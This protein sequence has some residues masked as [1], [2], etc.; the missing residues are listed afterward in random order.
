MILP[1]RGWRGVLLVALLLAAGDV[2][3]AQQPADN[4]VTNAVLPAPPIP[5][6]GVGST[7]FVGALSQLL[8]G[9]AAGAY[10]A[11]KN[12]PDA[13]ER[14]TIQ[15]AAIRF[16]KGIDAETIA[17]FAAEAPDFDFASV[18]RARLEAALDLTTASNETVIRLLGGQMP[19]GLDAQ[20]ALAKAYVADGQ[21]AR[22][23]R[24][25]RFIWVEEF[26][27]TDGE[28]KVQENLGTLLSQKDYWDRA[29][30]LLMHD[31]AS[32]TERIMS[33]LTPAEQSLARARIAVSR[34]SGDI[35]GLIE[36]VDSSLRDH[37][38]FQFTVA[39]WQRD[40][41]D[42][43]GAVAA[44][45]RVTSGEVPDA[46]EFW[47]ERR[48]IVR[49]ALAAGK[50]DL[51]YKAAAGYVAGPEG[52]LVEAHFHAGWVALVYLN[53]P[54][55]AAPH[56]KDM[57]RLATLPDS[58]SQ[59]R[60]WLG[61]AET[62]LGNA[63]AAKE[64]YE[65]AARFGSL[66]YGQLAREALGQSAVAV[67]P[68]PDWKDRLAAFDALPLV[69]AAR[70]LAGNG[71][72]TMAEPLVRRLGYSI[73]DPGDFVLAARLAQEID[74]HH[75]AI[76]IAD[77]ADQKG[78]SLDL[79][80]FPKDGIPQGAQLALADE[81]AVY[82]V[83]RQES[84]FDIDAVSSS[85]ARGLMQLMPSTAEGLAKKLGIGY[86][87]ARL[88]SDAAYNLLLGSSYLKTQLD[89]FGN[90]LLLAAAAYNA[91]GGNVNKWLASYG[92]PREATIDAISWTELIPFV[93]T[94]KY[95][96]KVMANYL[97][98]RARFGGAALTMQEALKR[99]PS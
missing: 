40:T 10:A 68:L 55:R 5:R 2:A 48:L 24:I 98:Y 37:P 17:R 94:R 44:L 42:L 87:P 30:H 14:R 39:Q 26:L 69:R 59:A 92:D 19:N 53:D 43:E 18:Y 67:R 3:W 66:F 15:W 57:V 81:A 77:V 61:R 27:T 52:R 70:L 95:V 36:T 72:K 54:R 73:T 21:K 4:I 20:I 32:G 64:S 41:G 63:A 60:Y 74:A 7:E 90:S 51:A 49:Q 85:G 80:H 93:E 79:F 29:V 65:K 76:L 83:A 71:Q 33:H 9:D 47:Y 6:L 88:T 11:A 91:G 35:A 62:A 82:A 23:A 56:F 28:T 50:P 89:R 99:I 84:H 25:A 86:S 16:G 97:V 34:K 78:Y 45:D 31:R 58:V 96:Q 75:I 8:A 13:I 46:A 12:L 1:T 38:L 22:A